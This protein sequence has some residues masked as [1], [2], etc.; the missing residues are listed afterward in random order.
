MPSP[1][2]GNPCS[3][4][5]PASPT[6]AQDAADAN[7]GAADSTAAQQQQAGA[8]NPGST[9][10]KPA[11]P[12]KP[13]PTKTGWIE[14]VLVDEQNNAVPGEA[15]AITLPDG[16]TVAEGTLDEKGFA[17][18]EGFDP[19]SCQVTFPDLDGGAWKSQ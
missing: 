6:A 7:P 16:E 4:V 9:P 13:D 8:G 15:Y 10:V 2:S 17:R 14:I 11:K 5:P 19:G 1:Q 18:V 12:L 3:L